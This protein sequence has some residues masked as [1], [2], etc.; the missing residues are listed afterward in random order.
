[1]SHEDYDGYGPS[2]FSLSKAE[3]LSTIRSSYTATEYEFCCLAP[4]AF[5][6]MKSAMISSPSFL[7]EDNTTLMRLGI[8]KILGYLTLT[9]LMQ[10]TLNK[11]S[12]AVH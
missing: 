12:C 1:M 9:I 8:L 4:N 6:E 7:L 11:I 2:S 10:L 3:L 5:R